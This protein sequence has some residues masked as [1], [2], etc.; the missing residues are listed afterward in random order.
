MIASFFEHCIVLLIHFRYLRRPK[1]LDL[2][3]RCFVVESMHCYC[4]LCVYASLA[5]ITLQHRFY[6]PLIDVDLVLSIPRKCHTQK[7]Y[8]LL[9][10]KCNQFVW[11]NNQMN[12]YF[13]T[14]SNRSREKSDRKQNNYFQQTHQLMMIDI[15]LSLVIFVSIINIK[16]SIQLKSILK[17]EKSVGYIWIVFTLFRGRDISVINFMGDTTWKIPP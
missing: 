2:M 10:V 16:C 13:E 9:F 12:P 11:L 4:L 14:K 6:L 3:D 17:N 7:T 5:R 15:C 1:F 8:D